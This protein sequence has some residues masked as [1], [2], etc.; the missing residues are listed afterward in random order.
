MDNAAVARILR[1]QVGVIA[2]RQLLAA[3]GTPADLER[4]LRR[5]ELVRLHP[6]VYVDH[7]GE[8]LWLQRAWAG[9]L[10]L[11]PAALADRSALRA[12]AGPRWG[13]HDEAA[14]IVIA[15]A[16]NRHVDPPPGCLVRR[17]SHFEERVLWNAGPP[18][19]RVEEAAID[20]AAAA[21]SDL[22]A[23]AVLADLC[24]GRVSTPTRLL[25]TVASRRRLPRRQWLTAVL[26]DIAGGTCS[27]LEHGYL[28]GVERAHGLPRAARQVSERSGG[29][30]VSRDA[31]Y[32]ECGLVVE[33]DGRLFHD[34]ADQRN[35]DLDR[36][37]DAA[38]AGRFTVRVGW[39]QVFDR[40]C[41]TAVRI[42]AL[43]RA[44]GWTGTVTPCG[45]ECP[46]GHP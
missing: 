26:S 45:P 40:P 9:V 15:V 4:M 14:P 30:R 2:R 33:L 34:S 38:V 5:K 12:A 22:D 16:Q 3:D 41:A 11:W 29:H 37:L 19:I 10:Y 13:G 32:E 27:V 24:Q 17:P 35:R 20:V 44:R 43:L 39:G 46:L 25:A 7:T 6:G 28:V 8:P 42:G 21:R 36:D 23:I 1:D 31:V 18:R